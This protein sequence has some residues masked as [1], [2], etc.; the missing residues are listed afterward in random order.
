MNL[1]D[2]LSSF[3]TKVLERIQMVGVG[4][5]GTGGFFIKP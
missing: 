3:S 2:D 4:V 1:Y 5:E